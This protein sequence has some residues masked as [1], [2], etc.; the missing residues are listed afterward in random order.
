ML[1]ATRF[2]VIDR[3]TTM[4]P[5]LEE[6]PMLEEI[7]HALLAVSAL[8]VVVSLIYVGLTDLP[9]APFLLGEAVALPAGVVLLALASPR[10]RHR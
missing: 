6:G 1:D 9:L 8:T 3:R 5:A 7:L 4:E 2:R 10:R